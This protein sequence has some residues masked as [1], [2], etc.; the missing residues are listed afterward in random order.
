MESLHVKNVEVKLEILTWIGGHV[1]IRDNSMP[2]NWNTIRL[3]G[4]NAV[5]HSHCDQYI[6]CFPQY[7]VTGPRHS[8]A[9]Y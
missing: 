9:I 4:L 8:N 6:H 1:N 7:D 2:V 5:K 3:Y